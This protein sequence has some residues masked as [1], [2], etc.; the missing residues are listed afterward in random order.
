MEFRQTFLTT[1]H[2]RLYNTFKA[3]KQ[4]ANF[5]NGVYI[6]AE[7]QA[8]ERHPNG[9]SGDKKQTEVQGVSLAASKG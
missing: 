2:E 7:E 1:V 4:P 8:E 5:H 6:E 3:N 9:T